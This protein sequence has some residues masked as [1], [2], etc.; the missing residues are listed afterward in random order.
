MA[1]MDFA[2]IEHMVALVTANPVSEIT[3]EQN[4]QR[5]CV[6]KGAFGPPA[7]HADAAPSPHADSVSEDTV[8]A[9]EAEAAAPEPFILPAPMVGMF[10][11]LSPPLRYAA[12]VVPGQVVGH[13]ESMKLMN[14]V[15]ADTGGHIL[16]VLAEDGVPVEYGQALLRLSPV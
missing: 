2:A 7:L 15:T 4:G 3:L 14:D 12:A 11:H 1:P 6:R 9:S 13:I 8:P 10:H 16:E 5:V